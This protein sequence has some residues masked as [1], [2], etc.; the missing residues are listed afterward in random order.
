MHPRFGRQHAGDAK[1]RIIMDSVQEGSHETIDRVWRRWLQ[2]C[3]NEVGAI[4]PLLHDA[5]TAD[6]GLLLR[7]FFERYRRADF[8]LDGSI[9]GERAT[10]MVATTIKGAAS[11]LSAAF[12]NHL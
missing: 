1:S 9:R 10:P 12:R 7:A 6:V 4:D 2:F 3:Q 5:P 8:H 11:S